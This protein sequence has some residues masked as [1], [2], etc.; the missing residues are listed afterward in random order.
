MRCG[1]ARF[2]CP[3]SAGDVGDVGAAVATVAAGFG[4]AQD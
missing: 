2:A 1:A 4:I 3:A